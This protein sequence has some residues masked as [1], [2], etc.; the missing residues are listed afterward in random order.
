MGKL[1]MHF[2]DKLVATAEGSRQHLLGQ[3]ISE[4]K[5]HL[6]INGVDVDNLLDKKNDTKLSKAD[7]GIPENGKTVGIL[8]T[9]KPE[10]AH[11]DV[12][13]EAANL[14]LKECPDTYF[15]L[16]GDGVER[17][18]IE[19]RIKELGI[20]SN[21]IIT[22]FRDDA[23]EIVGILDMSTLA[24]YPMV[25]T[26]SLAILES[27]AVGLPCVVTDVGSLSEMVFDDVNGYVV[28]HSNYQAFAEAVIKILKDD[29]LAKNMGL[30][31]QK[32]AVKKFHRNRMT[33]DTEDMFEKV[34]AEKGY[35][36]F[37]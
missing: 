36:F 28:P 10:K 14:I 32:I 35:R 15:L 13:L 34:L 27:M 16:I 11:A 29:E 8:A 33:K 4:N 23:A 20:G 5:L 25:E 37:E 26:F 22:G 6:I 17:P 12:F 1:L 2:T 9:F 18:R 3:G 24:S 21:V 31:S 30:N 7:F 19:E